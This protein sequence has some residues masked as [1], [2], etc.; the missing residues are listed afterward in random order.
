MPEIKTLRH[1]S[2]A[3]VEKKRQKPAVPAKEEPLKAGDYVKMSDGGVAGKI[4]SIQGKKAE[5]AFGGLRTFVELNKLRRSGTP[6][7]T[8]TTQTLSVSKETSDDIRRRQLNFKTEIDVRGL[9]ADEAIQ[10]VTYFIDDAIQFS[11]GKVRILHG[12]GHG[13]LKNLIRQQLNAN[14]GVKRYYDEDV[15]FGGAGIT[16]VELE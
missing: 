16:I 3:S 11:A 14:T 1:K 10:A 15:R 7:P 4:L 5:V 8:V 13:I 12:T 6:A 2:K 9:R